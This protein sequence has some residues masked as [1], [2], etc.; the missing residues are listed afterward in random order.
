M[1]QEIDG[2]ASSERLGI[3]TICLAH[4]AGSE[5]NTQRYL[6]EEAKSNSLLKVTIQMKLIEGD[7]SSFQM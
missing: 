7:R 2:G 5:S 4:L 6:L 3:V 1:I